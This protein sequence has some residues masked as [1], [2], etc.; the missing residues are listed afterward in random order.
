MASRRVLLTGANGFVGSHILEHFL[1]RS[2]SVLAVVRSAAKADRVK[3]DFPSYSSADLDFAIIPDITAEGAFDATLQSTKVDAVIHTAS[4]FN[5]SINKTAADFVEPAIR[6]TT[7]ILEATRKHGTSVKRVVITS[8]FAAIGNPRDL[9]GNGR[10]YTSDTWDPLTLEQ[11]LAG[12]MRDAYWGSKTLA[13]QAA[14]DFMS[15]NRPNFELVVLNPPLVLGPLRHSIDSLADINTSNGALW[16]TYLNSSISVP[17]PDNYLHIYVDVRDL[18]EAH[19]IGAFRP[20]VGNKRYL[21]SPGS[22]SNQEVAD[23]LRDAF[24]NVAD[25]IPL[26]TPGDHALPADS[27]KIDNS[28]AKELLGAKFIPLKTTLVDTARNLLELEKALQS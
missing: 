20:G 19:Y 3:R 21:F 25:R 6:G 1:T 5:Y 4:P 15:K 27:F 10:T 23:T 8:S 14:W 2:V 24:P 12:D 18:A 11:S 17:I 16:K 28:S 9:Q 22:M 26:G 13:E 7:E